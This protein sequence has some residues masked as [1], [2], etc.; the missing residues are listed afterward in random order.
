MPRTLLMLSLCLVTGLCNVKAQPGSYEMV[1]HYTT[2]NGLPQNNISAIA[3]DKNGFIWFGTQNGLVRF[4]GENLKVFNTIDIDP[5]CSNRIMGLAYLDDR[6]MVKDDGLEK[7]LLEIRGHNVV[8]K[9]PDQNKFLNTNT[10]SFHSVS[11]KPDFGKDLAGTPLESFVFIGNDGQEGFT[12]FPGRTTT[13]ERGLYYFNSNTKKSRQF[14]MEYQGG[15]GRY[16]VAGSRL[17]AFDSRSVLH[18]TDRT[19]PIKV[20]T[21]SLA[22]LLAATTESKRDLYRFSQS[23]ENVF[24]YD[25]HHVYLIKEQAPGNIDAVL[26]TGNTTIENEATF[27]YLPDKQLLFIGTTTAGVYVFRKRTFTALTFTSADMALIGDG[28]SANATIFKKEGNAFYDIKPLSD[29]TIL[30]KWGVISS[31]GR[32]KIDSTITTDFAEC[33]YPAP[34]NFFLFHFSHGWDVVFLDQQFY[35]PPGGRFKM[36]DPTTLFY[37]SGSFI[38]KDTIYLLYQRQDT[39]RLKGFVSPGDKPAQELAE[40]VCGSGIMANSGIESVQTDGNNIVYIGTKNGLYRLN[41]KANTIVSMAGFEN[42]AVRTLCY[43]A[44]G[45]LWVGT[46]GKG[47]YRYRAGQPLLTLPLDRNKNLTV[48][49]A[50]IEDKSGYFW[51]ST[52]NGLFRFLK[53]DLDN[54]TD[55]SQSLF[56]NYF[57]KSYGFLTNEFTGGGNPNVINLKDGNFVFPSMKGLVV[58]NPLKV[59]VELF[60]QDIFIDEIYLDKKKQQA[61]G[62]LLS[63]APDFN[64]VTFKLSFP[65]YGERY[66]IQAEYR[67]SGDNAGW[68]PIGGDG[69]IA[70]NRLAHGKYTLSFRIL[71]GYGAAGFCQK[72]ISFEV[73]PFWY[74]SLW[75]FICLGLGISA[76]T[77]MLFRARI[78]NVKRRNEQLENVVKKRTES[79]SKSEEK[80]RK[81]SEFRSQVTSLVL[82][83]IRSPIHFL[84]KLSGDIYSA[85]EGNTP[86]DIRENLRKLNMST[87]KISAYTQNLLSWIN[88]QEDDYQLEYTP[89]ILLDIFMDMC[90]RYELSAAQNRNHLSYSV[91]PDLVVMTRPDIL[92]I[93]LRNILDNAIKYTNDG[94]VHI[95]A[96]KTGDSICIAVADT[97]ISIPPEKLKSLGNYNTLSGADTR[98]GMGYRFIHDL[99]KKLEGRIEIKSK[100]GEGTQV[101]I[102]LPIKELDIK[103]DV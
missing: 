84:S 62:D 59:P 63:L 54:I 57:N 48:V 24:F 47:W 15:T 53:K 90:E 23:G 103:Y 76:I 16:F 75:F 60:S 65:F 80:L 58:F 86:D 45:T 28:D 34:N 73:K 55:S 8:V 41:R 22:T 51:V 32:K 1:A 40:M 17:Y 2:E 100:L 43:D 94:K 50:F 102:F 46:Y 19:T 36:P 30:T 98:S 52:I 38:I 70:F 88:T 5:N 99:L 96:H 85:S 101:S 66:N 18:G 29:S 11:S 82:H 71:K 39:L 89:V 27:L 10:N 97:G 14:V 61:Y 69:V 7:Y 35:F 93:V 92:E 79:L 56:F 77:A 20:I 42:I 64:N 68:E 31:S 81:N 83:D 25:Q 67:L 3:E 12:F 4:D 13:L 49:H 91:S 87:E 9:V 74:Q 72:D 26:L 78:G 44:A 95:S 21:G 33:L 37:K 6:L